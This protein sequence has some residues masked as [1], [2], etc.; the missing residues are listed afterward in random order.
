MNAETNL[1]YLLFDKLCLRV[2]WHHV[3]LSYFPTR[4]LEQQSSL[5]NEYLMR[6]RGLLLL[7]FW[8]ATF[9]AKS[10]IKTQKTQSLE[11]EW[12]RKKSSIFPYIL[13]VRAVLPILAL[14]WPNPNAVQTTRICPE[15]TLPV[16][17][18]LYKFRT[19]PVVS[20]VWIGED[21]HWT[22]CGRK[23]GP[24]GIP[25]IPEGPVHRPTDGPVADGDQFGSCENNLRG[26]IGVY[27]LKIIR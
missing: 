17:Q 15:Q 19:F 24:R 1:C 12:K 23:F 6:R 9:L 13:G 26:E 21:A 2:A 20:K 25:N 16:L 27:R 14:S 4:Q 7:A 10:W 5:L 8:K 3:S 22:V 11:K 18:T